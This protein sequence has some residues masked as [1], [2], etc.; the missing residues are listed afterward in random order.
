MPYLHWDTDRSRLATASKIKEVSHQR[1]TLAEV[2][3][4][5]RNR[6]SHAPSVME[7]ETLPSTKGSSS[8]HYHAHAPP[9]HPRQILGQLLRAAA[10][11]LEAM[12]FHVDER[13]ISDYIHAK[14]PLH[15]RRTLDQ[16]YY[17][18]LKNTGTRDRDQVVYRAT[19]PEAHDHDP[20]WDTCG[21]CK[22][23]V[24][25][26]SRLIMVDQLWLWILDESM[27]SRS[28][29]RS[30]STNRGLTPKQKPSSRASRE[31]GA[32]T[33][34]TRRQ[35]TRASACAW[36]VRGKARSRRHTTSP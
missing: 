33:D 13:L 1:F 29:P 14:P 8:A 11:L 31:N 6:L 5:A 16:S 18:A 22:D 30:L 24:K 17:G 25:K 36:S 23:D 32:R 15:P 2:L 19:A 3:S 9:R 28:F 21:Q 26:E 35:S 20:S 27:F 34:Q 12:E 7:L 10:A 4:K